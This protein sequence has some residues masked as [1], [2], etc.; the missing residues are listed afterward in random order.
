MLHKTIHSM[1]RSKQRVCPKVAIDQAIVDQFLNLD[2]SPVYTVFH[3]RLRDRWNNF[4]AIDE[5]L[6]RPKDI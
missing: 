5:N 2:V 3:V 4:A 6:L 1:G